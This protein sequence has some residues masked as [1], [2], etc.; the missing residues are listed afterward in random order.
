MIAFDLILVIIILGIG[1]VAGILVRGFFKR[2]PDDPI[3]YGADERK[4]FAATVKIGSFIG[5]FG[6]FG[7]LAIAL[8]SYGLSNGA[9]GAGTTGSFTSTFGA[10]LIA[11]AAA[12]AVGSLLGF[13]FGIPRT[14][15]PAS[16]A[17]VAGAAAQGGP[18]A[19]AHAVLGANTNLERI[20]DWLTTLLIGATLVQIKDI[21]EWVGKLGDHL[22]AGAITNQSLI[23]IIVVYFFALSF[24]GVYLITRLY[25]TTALTDTLNL[26]TGS[27]GVSPLDA[28][29]AKLGSLTNVSDPSE[30]GSAIQ[31]YKG[32][33]LDADQKLDPELNALLA[34]V[35]AR[36]LST[37]K[38][39]DPNAI[40][41]LVKSA[42]RTAAAD[43]NQKN[44]LK[45]DLASGPLATT[46]KPLNDELIKLLS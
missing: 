42:V 35:A 22:G 2:A 32:W 45:N 21:V 13:I 46:G 11:G 27:G 41:E 18:S 30:L 4:I 29:K 23:P 33:P 43:P 3:S 38:A 39:E 9:A 31:V 34:R 10:N 28:L 20:S 37:G 40:A 5:V 17:A 19:T 44:R 26:L 8:V 15:D 14:L 6:A 36:Y 24:L 7:G 16:R 12:A 25:L 1:M